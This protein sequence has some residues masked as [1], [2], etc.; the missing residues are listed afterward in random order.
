MYGEGLVT[1]QGPRGPTLQLGLHATYVTN[2]MHNLVQ[3]WHV[4]L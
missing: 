1:D 3:G 2:D 4:R